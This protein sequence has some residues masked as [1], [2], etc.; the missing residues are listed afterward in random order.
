[1]DQIPSE[2]SYSRLITKLEQ[3]DIIRKI[4]EDLVKQAMEEGFLEGDVV[5]IDSTIRSL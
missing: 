1:M 4:Q 3:S 2:A 5:A